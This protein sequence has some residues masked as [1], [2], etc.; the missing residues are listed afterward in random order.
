MQRLGVFLVPL[1][2]ACGSDDPQTQTFTLNFA[3][4]SGN[5]ALT[6]GQTTAGGGNVMVRDFR[7]FV[8]NVQL[9]VG[10]TSV[11]LDLEQDGRWQVE[12]IAL[13]DFE[14]GQ[15]S[16]SETGNADVN[17]SV[18]GTAVVD[19]D[20]TGVSFD[21]GVPFAQNHFDTA[22]QPSPLNIASMFWNWR[23]GYKFIRIDLRGGD[24]M[25]VP[26]NVHLGS[27]ACDGASPVDAPSM[28]CGRP[29]IPSY[30]LD[31]FNPESGEIVFDLQGLL[32]GADTSTNTAGTPPGCMSA[33]T[34][35]TDCTPVFQNLGLDFM[36]GTCSGSCA[37]Q[38]FV[39]TR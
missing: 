25:D 8:S 33:P 39:R 21:I 36:T 24:M 22:T 9:L 35:P 23:G 5:E 2:A 32:Q 6:C 27:T 37:G 16:C 18:R 38:N 30:T 19:G 3:A 31:A 15:G 28:P 10:G 20:V 7:L 26:Y 11:S 1:A 12:N 13:L 29:N 34:D 4:V 17:T 14:N